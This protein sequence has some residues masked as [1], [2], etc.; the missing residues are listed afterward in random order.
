M[1][2]PLYELS[3]RLETQKYYLNFGMD[4]ALGDSITCASYKQEVNLVFHQLEIIHVIGSS[5]LS[6]WFD[7]SYSQFRCYMQQTSQSQEKMV[8]I[9]L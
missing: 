1:T 2:I 8:F 5:F 3:H 7:L 9:S 4:F 6:K